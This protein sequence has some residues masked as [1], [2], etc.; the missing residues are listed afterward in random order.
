M[1]RRSPAGVVH[2]PPV[3]SVGARAE[4]AAGIYLSSPAEVAKP[5]GQWPPPAGDR[6]ALGRYIVRAT[7]AECHGIGSRGGKPPPGRPRNPDLRIVAGYD[8]AVFARL[9]RTGIAVG[10]REVGLMTE[11]ARG[12]FRHL[13]DDE[14][15]AVHGYLQAVAAAVP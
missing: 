8:A 6:H 2:P 7:C 5:G 11:V 12:R 3:F 15:A 13:Q 14:I 4:M 1:V 10:D 9:M